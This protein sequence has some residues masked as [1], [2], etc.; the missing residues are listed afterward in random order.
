MAVTGVGT[1][2]DIPI[3]NTYTEEE[4]EWIKENHT[5]G[6]HKEIANMMT[7]RFGKKRTPDAIRGVVF[8]MGLTVNTP[9]EPWTDAQ[10]RWLDANARKYYRRM[11]DMVRDF[12]ARFKTSRTKKSLYRH[13]SECCIKNTG[14][15]YAQEE[16]LKS[17]EGDD[18]PM[19]TR[20]FNGR[21]GENKS[22]NAIRHH[23][24]N[25]RRKDG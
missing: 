8:R 7:A 9:V 16:W 14:Y 18:Y 2:F 1:E 10:E 25:I 5:C 3:R 23:V 11:D 24:K 4:L 12:N 20:M 17:V 22:L 15:T 13:M 19:I 6:T 21:F